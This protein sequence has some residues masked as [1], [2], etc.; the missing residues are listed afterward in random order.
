MLSRFAAKHLYDALQET[1]REVD[2]NYLWS[3][4]INE[5]GFAFGVII[6]T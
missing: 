4:K 3:E 6:G 1:L 5:G 2:M